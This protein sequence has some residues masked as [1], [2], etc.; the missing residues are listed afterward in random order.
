VGHADAAGVDERVGQV[1]GVVEHRAGHGGQADLVAVVGDAGHHA[2]LDQ[3]RVQHTL[4]QLIGREVGGAEAEDVGDGDG[5]VGGAHHV[6]DDAADTGVRAAE[7]LDGRRVVVR[8][9]LD[10]DGDARAC[11]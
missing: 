4:G 10:G 5:V 7:G 9:G 11:S 8:L 1:A 3:A 6:A 2:A